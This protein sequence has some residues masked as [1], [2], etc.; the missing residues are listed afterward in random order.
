M[1]MAS[2]KEDERRHVQATS[3]FSKIQASKVEGP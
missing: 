3:N 1:P 2:T